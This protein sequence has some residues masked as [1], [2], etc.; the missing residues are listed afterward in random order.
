MYSSAPHMKQ[1]LPRHDDSSSFSM[2]KGNSSNE[3]IVKCFTTM[4]SMESHQKSCEMQRTCHFLN[5]LSSSLPVVLLA[6]KKI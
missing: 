4:R 3:F 2:Y 1:C 5:M 6:D